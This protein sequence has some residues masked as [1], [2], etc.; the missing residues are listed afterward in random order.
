M[1]VVQGYAKN[2]G[3]GGARSKNWDAAKN[4]SPV[5][6]GPGFNPQSVEAHFSTHDLDEAK[7]GGTR[8]KNLNG[9]TRS[10]NLNA[11]SGGARSKNG[12]EDNALGLFCYSRAASRMP[13]LVSQAQKKLTAISSSKLWRSSR[14]WPSTLKPR[15]ARRVRG[16]YATCKCGSL[17]RA[18]EF[19]NSLMLGYCENEQAGM[20]VLL[21]HF[22][23][24]EGCGLDAGSFVPP[25]KALASLASIERSP[26]TKPNLLVLRRSTASLHSQASERGFD[27][28][29][30]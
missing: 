10:K 27:L 25:L 5:A 30:C 12:S 28:I 3:S 17:R 23:Q 13:V 24:L 15:G 11:E 1:D 20:V 21:F 2:G 8:S 19:W 18:F 9:G 7:N 26:E 6:G 4:A 14:E 16:V 29:N 22:M